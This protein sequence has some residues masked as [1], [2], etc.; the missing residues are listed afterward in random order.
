MQNSKLGITTMSMYIESFLNACES[1]HDLSIKWL[2][3]PLLQ[4]KD[5]DNLNP[6]VRVIDIKIEEFLSL[7]EDLF[8]Y[9]LF[10]KKSTHPAFKLLKTLYDK[11]DS[12]YSSKHILKTS[13][14]EKYFKDSKWLEIQALAK[15]TGETLEIFIKE[16]QSA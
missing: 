6:D 5:W 13:S 3:D 2:G 15:K 7:S 16:S 11:V 9:E 8:E 12:F 14:K 4:K 1:L 10:E